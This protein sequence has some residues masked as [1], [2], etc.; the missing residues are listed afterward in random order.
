MADAIQTLDSGWVQ[1]SDQML[2]SF[3]CHTLSGSVSLPV[4]EAMQWLG[5][6]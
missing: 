4:N 6:N 5:G 3:T 1:R 2:G